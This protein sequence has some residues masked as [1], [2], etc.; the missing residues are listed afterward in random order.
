MGSQCN[1]WRRVDASERIHIGKGYSP[2]CQEISSKKL[3]ASRI[4]K[5][6]ISTTVEEEALEALISLEEENMRTLDEQLVDIM[7]KALTQGLVTK[8]L[9][10]QIRGC[11]PKL[12]TFYLI[13][14]IHKNH[15]DPPGRPIVSDSSHPISTVRGIP[16]GQFLRARRICS[17]ENNFE[18]QAMDLTR[19]FTERGYCKRIIKRGYL[20]ASKTLRNQLLYK[21][22]FT[23]R[24]QDRPEQYISMVL[25]LPLYYGECEGVSTP[26]SVNGFAA[27][28]K[29]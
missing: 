12:P 16:V 21:D 23:T 4:E 15:L 26:F 7:E 27:R 8:K 18:K 5:D 10:E 9:V 2:V 25:F 13:P 22:S 28:T 11:Y 17:D 14:K 3:H 19:R 20:R 29:N 1:N 24:E 6:R